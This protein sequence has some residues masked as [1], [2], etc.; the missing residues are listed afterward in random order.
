MSVE[1][2]KLTNRGDPITDSQGNPLPGVRITFILADPTSRPPGRPID[3]WDAFSGERIAPIAATAITATTDSLETGGLKIGEFD[4]NLWPTGRSSTVVQYLCRV[5]IPNIRPFL[6]S[7]PDRGITMQWIDFK[8]FSSPIAA[9]T[10]QSI[11]DLVDQ[12]QTAVTQAEAQAAL[13]TTRSGETA[14]DRRQTGEDRTQ[15]GLD[16]AAT[17][18]DRQ[19]VENDTAIILANISAINTVSGIHSDVTQTAAIHQDITTVSGIHQDVTQT[20]AI[21]ADVTQTAAIHQ[22]ITQAAAIYQEIATVS[23]IHSDVTQTAAI[24]S[25]VTQAAAIHNDITNV[26]MIHADVTQTAAIHSDVTQTAAI[27]EDVSQVSTIHNDVTVCAGNLSNISSS[28]AALVTLATNLIS[29][30]AIIAQ[31]FPIA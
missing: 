12:A 2:I 13:S 6:A 3:A 29:T 28:A 16:R 18:S 9:S 26:S 22:D 20:A 30:Q 15:T 19:T 10:M 23:G 1:T 14:D 4:I 27:H 21:H 25:D 31:H 8:A 17:A 11:L 7:L 24:H 5:D